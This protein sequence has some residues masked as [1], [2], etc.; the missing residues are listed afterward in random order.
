MPIRVKPKFSTTIVFSL[1]MESV[2]KKTKNDGEKWSRKSI[3]EIPPC[4]RLLGVLIHGDFEPLMGFLLCCGSLW[5]GTR[6]FIQIHC[7]SPWYT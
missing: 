5:P 3:F 4:G 7:S 2:S 1:K 6:L